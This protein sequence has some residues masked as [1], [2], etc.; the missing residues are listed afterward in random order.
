MESPQSPPSVHQECETD[1]NT[2]IPEETADGVSSVV[3]TKELSVDR[4]A[5]TT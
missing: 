4:T 5:H 3:I 1:A 2:A